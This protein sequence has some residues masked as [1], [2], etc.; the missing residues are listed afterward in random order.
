MGN[1]LLGT[2]CF[3]VTV[4]TEKVWQFTEIRVNLKLY[5]SVIDMTLMTISFF[6]SAVKSLGSIFLLDM[7]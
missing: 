5:K 7:T 4:F 6:I 2:K 1:V 3:P